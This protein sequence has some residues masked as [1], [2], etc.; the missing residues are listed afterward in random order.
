MAFDKSK[1]YGQALGGPLHGLAVQDEKFYDETTGHEFV[2]KDGKRVK[3]SS[4][5][6]KKA[7]AT[8][9]EAAPATT[10]IPRDLPA[11]A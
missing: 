1:P 11:E 9:T 2:E 3:A 10:D 7:P 8:K 4:P 5:A 6:A